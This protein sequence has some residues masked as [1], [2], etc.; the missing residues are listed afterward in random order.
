MN[1]A[2]VAPEAAPVSVFSQTAMRGANASVVGILAAAL[3]DPVWASAILAPRDFAAALVGFVLLTA[4]RV[5]PLAVVA[6]GAVAGILM[7]A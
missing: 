3:Y 2:V 6:L 4:W 7:A 5:T 1:G